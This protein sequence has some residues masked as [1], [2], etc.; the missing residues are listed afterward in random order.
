MRLF[1]QNLLIHL[2]FVPYLRLRFSEGYICSG[3]V[4]V[5]RLVELLAILKL[6]LQNA[7]VRSSLDERGNVLFGNLR[8][9]FRHDRLILTLKLDTGQ[10]CVPLL[11]LHWVAANAGLSL[12]SYCARRAGTHSNQGCLFSVSSLLLLIKLLIFVYCCHFAELHRLVGWSKML[13][14][15]TLLFEWDAVVSRHFCDRPI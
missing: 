4:S 2:L 13:F 5:L 1:L 11:L 12:L 6:L 7:Q 15:F 8:P 9:H 3:Q 10:I 14:I